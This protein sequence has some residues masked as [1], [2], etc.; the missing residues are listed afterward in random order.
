MSWD[1]GFGG[2]HGGFSQG[3]GGWG[4]GAGSDV[5]QHGDAPQ[6][7]GG[8]LQQ[9]GGDFQQHSGLPGNYTAQEREYYHQLWTHVDPQGV[10]YVDGSAAG[11]LLMASGLTQEVLHHIWELADTGQTGYLTEDRFFAACRL[12]AHAQANQPPS[13]E[14][15]HREPH[16]LPDF[17]V[18]RQRAPSETSQGGG[19]SPAP[20]HHGGA[21]SEISEL[22]PVIHGGEDSVRYAASSAQQRGRSPSPRA[23]TSDRWAP[24]QR[25]KRKYA[26]LFVRTDWDNDGYV[27]A[28]EARELVERSGL[29][30]AA[31]EVAWEHSDFD[32]DGRFTFQEFVCLVHLITCSLRGAQLPGMHEPLPSALTDALKRLESPDV[33]VAEREA[34]RSRSQSPGPSVL[35]SPILGHADPFHMNS[36]DGSPVGACSSGSDHVLT[37]WEVVCELGAIPVY[38]DSSSSMSLDKRL[39]RGALVEEIMLRGDRLNYRKLAGDGP[40]DGWVSVSESGY[41]LVRPKRL[42]LGASVQQAHCWEVIGGYEKGGITVRKESSLKSKSIKP[43]LAR[44]AF[45]EQLALEG[46]RLQYRLLAGEGPETGWVSI[47]DSGCELLRPRQLTSSRREGAPGYDT[48]NNMGAESGGFGAIG[49]IAGGDFGGGAGGDFDSGVGG[50]FGSGA[51]HDFGGAGGDFGTGAGGTFE[52]GTLGNSGD[53]FGGSGDGNWTDSQGKK[54]KKNKKNKKRLD[55]SGGFGGELGSS[56]PPPDAYSDVFNSHGHMESHQSAIGHVPRH[57]AG[58]PNQFHAV[59]EADRAISGVLRREVDELHDAMKLIQ[60]ERSQ[61]MREIQHEQQDELRLAGQRA[62]LNAQLLDAKGRLGVLR[63]ERRMLT[64]ISLSLRRNNSHVADE[65]AHL[66]RLRETEE[67]SLEVARRMAQHIEKSYKGLELH[68]DTLEQQRKDIAQELKQE[69]E[70]QRVEEQ[71]NVEL[72]NRL[73][74]LRQKHGLQGPFQLAAAVTGGIGPGTGNHAGPLRLGV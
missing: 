24:S 1:Q 48:S 39:A 70:L 40:Q 56:Y 68:G 51:G 52:T 25:E 11:N 53:L 63:D 46:D 7:H 29:G 22:Q 18:Q 12:V 31:L 6:H 59:T 26:S 34:S 9:H 3:S 69:Q 74:D 19:G 21:F 5:Q 42:T 45:V 49:G 47:S 50:D 16:A 41:E 14:L 35:P 72:R 43:K 23:F 33:L 62:C 55:S 61:L 71:S 17:D 36:M 28:Q 37:A 65:L 64:A 44:G 8:D 66:L 57:L 13:L 67:Q 32:R 38:A 2:G 60:D 54:D 20:S 73:N 58:I 30:N 4:G 10:G 27:Q 15:E